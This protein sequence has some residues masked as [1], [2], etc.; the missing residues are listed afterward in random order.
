[1]FDRKSGYC[2]ATEK[3]E[4]QRVRRENSILCERENTPFVAVSPDLSAL[5]ESR[6]VC[7]VTAK[8]LGSTF[9]VYPVGQR[10]DHPIYFVELS[11]VLM[12]MVENHSNLVGE[13]GYLAPIVGFGESREAAGSLV[14]VPLGPGNRLG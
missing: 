14:L 12:A 5:V 2:K 7:S 9:Q 1:M 8:V 10:C 3:E 11:A 6:D 13:P 4:K